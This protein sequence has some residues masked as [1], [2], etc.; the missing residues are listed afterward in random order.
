MGLS[1]LTNA[2]G[3]VSITSVRIMTVHDLSCVSRQVSYYLFINTI[4]MYLILYCYFYLL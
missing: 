1:S 3:S 4:L 2:R